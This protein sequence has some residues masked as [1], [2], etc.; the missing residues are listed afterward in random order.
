[1]RARGV[2]LDDHDSVE[3]CVRT[4]RLDAEALAELLGEVLDAARRAAGE[5]GRGALQARPES[6]GWRGSG[7]RHPTICR[8]ER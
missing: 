8:C 4:D 3:N 1:M 2:L 7:C 5:A 6:C